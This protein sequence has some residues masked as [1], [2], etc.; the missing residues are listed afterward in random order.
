MKFICRVAPEA[1]GPAGAKRRE[2]RFFL[3]KK[4][5]GEYTVWEFICR[6]VPET[7]SRGTELRRDESRLYK[8][9]L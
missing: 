1:N 5:A 3:K 6:L 4:C 7:A 8:G 9:K 2:K